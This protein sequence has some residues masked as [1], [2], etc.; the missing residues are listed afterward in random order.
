M[1]FPSDNRL[2]IPTLDL[3]LQ[4]IGVPI[5]VWGWGGKSRTTQHLGTWHCYVDDSRFSALL[6]RPEQMAHT[7]A[8]AAVEPN[9]SLY[10]DT[11]IALAIAAIYR[12]RW[13]ARCWQGYGLRVFVDLNVPPAVL[14]LEE[15]RMGI[16]PGWKAFATRGYERRI[17]D[18]DREYSV[19]VEIAGGNPLML[20]V[21]GG[22]EVNRWCLEHGVV[23]SG[24]APGKR[25][26][27]TGEGSS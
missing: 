10:V 1:L 13:V 24:Y 21:G 5:P 20:V 8:V 26:H 16:P 9:I 15:F 19:A 17:D 14:E 4:A 23:H 6:D 12:K 22:R 2:G 18:L 3:Q 27:S 11:P 25:F 7:Q